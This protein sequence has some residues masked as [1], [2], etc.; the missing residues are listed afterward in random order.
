[1]VSPLM[2]HGAIVCLTVFDRAAGT[3]CRQARLLKR[4]TLGR[5]MLWPSRTGLLA[6]TGMQHREPK[7]LMIKVITL[8]LTAIHGFL[9]RY[10]VALTFIALGVHAIHCMPAPRDSLLPGCPPAIW[11]IMT[12]V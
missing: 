5:L 1:M 4:Q 10:R 12:P 3:A 6:M 7:S 2:T 11:Q 9:L 8:R